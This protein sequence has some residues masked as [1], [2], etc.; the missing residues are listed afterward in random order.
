MPYRIKSDL[1]HDD[2]RVVIESQHRL[3]C[4]IRSSVAYL[5]GSSA[6]ALP[7]L[8]DGGSAGPRCLVLQL[9]FPSLVAAGYSH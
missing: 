9:I 1:R 5:R 2:S 7:R 6:S 8:V 3:I 4:R